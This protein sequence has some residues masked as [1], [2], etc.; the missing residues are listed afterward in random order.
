MNYLAHA[1]LSNN[2]EGL[3]LGN[4][5]ADHLRGNNFEHLSEE[6]KKGIYMHRKIDQFTDEHPS[7]KQSKRLFYDG[8]EKYSGVLVDIYFDHL[9]ARDFISYSQKS[10]PEFASHV[11]GIYEKHKH[12]LPENS[13][14]FLSYVLSNNIYNAYSKIEGIEKVL[15]HLSHRI[16]HGVMLNDSVTL[17]KKNE[18]E[19]QENFTIFMKDIVSKFKK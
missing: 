16:N 7:F 18:I 17:F 10:L 15:F 3:L 6:V 13:E 5:I 19:L 8:F 9:L 12:V 4:F 14:R 1:Y 2:D 11:Y